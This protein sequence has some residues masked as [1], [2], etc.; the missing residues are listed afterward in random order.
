MLAG[1][2]NAG[3][4]SLFNCLAGAGRAIVTETPG[5]TRDLVTETVDVEGI[6]M[7][8]VDTA[9]VHGAAADPIEVEGIARA[10]A[11]RDVAH[12]IVVVLDR[13]R[14]LDGD[15]RAL[16]DATAGRPRVVVANKAISWRPGMAS[17]ST[18]RIRSSCPRRRVKESTV[19]AQRS[20]SCRGEATARRAGDHER[21]SR[22]SAD[23]RARGARPR[24]DAARAETPEEFVLA[25][26]TEARRRLEEVTGAR[27]SDDV[28]H[29]IFARFCIGK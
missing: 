21:A 17:R 3:K 23:E 15:D 18:V 10:V 5:T 22:R 20:W 9:G 8:V 7:T 1:R 25:D 24:P 13:S 28:L 2:P 19:C 14:P 27:T 11:A 26:L 16:L 12:L 4:S 29:E 6:P